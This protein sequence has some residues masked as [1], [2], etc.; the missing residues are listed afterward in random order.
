MSYSFNT[1]HCFSNEQ[2]SILEIEHDKIC[3]W[4][5]VDH[6][7]YKLQYLELSSTSHEVIS[8]NNI[9]I[10]IFDNSEIRFDQKTGFA[11]FTC[12][13]NNHLVMLGNAQKNILDIIEKYML[14]S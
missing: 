4:F 5:R 6:T 7:D 14:L 2:I 9:D 3:K 1:L 13:K 10:R 12:P 11:K 8:G